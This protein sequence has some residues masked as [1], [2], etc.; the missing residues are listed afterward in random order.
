MYKNS[1]NKKIKIGFIVGNFPP[2]KCGIGDYTFKLVEKL[3]NNEN[4]KISVITSTE[5][6]VELAGVQIYNEVKNWNISSWKTI[7]RLIKEI[8]PDIIHYQHPSKLYKKYLLQFYLPYLI[9]KHFKNVKFLTTIHEFSESPWYAKLWLILLMKLSDYLIFVNQESEILANKL[10]AST[11][12]RS[13]IIPIGSA[14]NPLEFDKGLLL[15]EKKKISQ[16][17]EFVIGYF[18]FIN[19]DKGLDILIK[20]LNHLVN[21]QRKKIKLCIIGEL[22]NKIKYH[23]YI[24]NLVTKFK[25]KNNIFITGYLDSENVS[26]YFNLIDICVLPFRYGSSIRRSSLITA[27]VHDVST[28]TTPSTN[29]LLLKENKNIIYF[30]NSNDLI[31]KIVKLESDK[32]FYLKIKNGTQ[33]LKSH[34]MW[35]SIANKTFE[36]Y[37]NIVSN[38]QSNF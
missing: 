14:I 4:L 23:R 30:N 24:N 12:N 36:F 19:K 5:S 27:L 35:P 13:R 15:N 16:N 17:N 29:N 7:K 1:E 10:R 25:L 8:N 28:I 37:K 34:F 22:N 18:G 31:T 11:K 2:I 33:L 38:E 20:A 6:N 9:K 3:K 21:Q 26:K 32:D